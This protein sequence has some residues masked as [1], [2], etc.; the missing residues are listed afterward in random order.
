ME[1]VLK[2]TDFTDKTTISEVSINDTHE[3]YVLEDKDR[4]LFQEMSLEQ[5]NKLKVYG[6]TAIPYGKYEV[7]I[8]YSM[9]FKKDLPILLNVPGYEGIR[10][11]LGNTAADTHGCLLPGRVK[12][13]DKVADSTFA[14]NQLF[15]K[16]KKALLTERVYITITK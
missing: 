13:V 3:C 1:I 16:I 15:A 7:K 12:L 11:H 8:T 6:E 2:R 10:I 4:G 5:L 14:F 9:R